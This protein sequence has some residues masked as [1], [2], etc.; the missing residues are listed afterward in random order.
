MSDASTAQTAPKAATAH[1]EPA[2]PTPLTP[3][4]RIVKRVGRWTLVVGA[5]LVAIYLLYRT[6]QVLVHLATTYMWF[7]SVHQSSVYST[8]LWPK[9]W[10]FV[11][12]AV[13]G[14]AA[15]AGTIIAVRRAS[16]RLELRKDQS[17][18]AWFRRYERRLWP[19]VLIIAI[20]VPAV[21]VG[22]A[23]SS[24]WQTYLL[25]AHAQPWGQSDPQ[26][27]KDISFFVEV[28]PFHQLLVGLF[29]QVVK[30]ALMVALVGSY[31]YGGWR[32][33]G[34][35]RRLTRAT[36]AIFSILLACYFV[37]RIFNYW[38]TQYN[39]ITENKGPVTGVSYTDTHA[40][41]P[42]MWPLIAV[43]FIA[44]LILVVNFVRWH[45]VR[46]VAAA[47]ALVVAG[48]FVFGTLWPSAVF[49]LIE[50]PSAATRDLTEIAHNQAATL[51]AF[52]LQNAVTSTTVPTQTQSVSALQK[53][54]QRT[55]QF[56][57]IDPN[58]MS[59]TFNVKQELQAYYQFKSPLDVD[60]YTV[61]GKSQDVVL[62]ARELKG[63]G[64]NNSWV[65]QHLV[66]TH[67]YGVVAAP[68]NVMDNANESPYFLNAGMPPAKD[69][70]VTQPEIYFGQ[71][72]PGY[73]IVGEPKGSKRKLE[74]NHPAGSGPS[75]SAYTTYKGDGGI[76]IGSMLRRF[77]FADTLNSPNI[78]FSG[79]INRSSQLLMIR[80]PRARVGQVAPWLTLDGD[81]Y[82]AIVDGQVD[83]IV[84]G[85]T[86]TSN[87]PDSQTVNLRSAT[88]N[89]VTA[90][91]TVATQPNTKVN[92]MRNSV[93]AV[94]NAYTGKVTLYQ[95]DEGQQ[96]DPLL[97]AWEK[98]FPGLVQPQSSIPAALMP[99]LRYP[100]DLFDV[101]RSLLAQ[102]HV[103]DP[104][105]FYSGND[106]WKVPGDPTTSANQSQP[107][108][109]MSMSPTGSGPQQY[110]LSSPMV[111]LSG[112]ELAAFITVNS[113]PGPNYGKFTLLT[114]P[115]GNG[116]EAPLQVQNDIESD[117][118]VSRVLTLERGGG[119]RVVLGTLEAVPLGGQILYVEPV[120]SQA[121]GST[122]FPILR[123]VIAL[124]GNGDPAF[125]KVLSAAVNGAIASG[126]SK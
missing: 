98:V 58:R 103:T 50:K 104:A 119:S 38:E 61:N 1:L 85:Y 87:Y 106:F 76:P 10:L 121:A 69:I 5:V 67:G 54:G 75:N 47:V 26:F 44:A 71:N 34:P 113:E 4:E 27:H 19:V 96:P 18:R 62:A 86:T 126:L 125:S 3:L 56:Q 20:L 24:N 55:A 17:V 15:G 11:I 95:W 31:F 23:A 74:F 88:Q 124:Y 84:D 109:Y 36:T 41:L 64:P 78:L 81:V 40:T 22:S 14:G 92:Y 120:Y 57:I 112:R 30:Y 45:R 115:G 51:N 42:A 35:G 53:Q 91:A 63:T 21:R 102:Y 39:V 52:G 100:R 16:P 25:W 7:D 80:D 77:L 68:T 89:S 29:A 110:S 8:M 33:R 114:F 66:Y 116:G 28:L 37:V 93:K 6:F 94:V 83:W 59:P 2:A 9:I 97:S 90:K 13:I 105:A 107:P 101:Q 123:H 72:E 122:S 111:T 99:H 43:A 118:N 73:S 32:F 49:Q 46:F 65:N 108:A 117:T 82:P 60:H 79:D 12:F 70:P 48:S